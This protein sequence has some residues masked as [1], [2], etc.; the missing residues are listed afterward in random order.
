MKPA[1]LGVGL[2]VGALGFAAFLGAVGADMAMRWYDDHHPQ[3]TSM[4][5]P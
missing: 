3:G 4:A 2:F 5:R 1:L